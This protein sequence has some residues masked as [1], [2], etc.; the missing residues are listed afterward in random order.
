VVVARNSAKRFRCVPV[1]GDNND[2]NNDDCNSNNTCGDSSSSHRAPTETGGG[3]T[4]C[5]DGRRSSPEQVVVR[6]SPRAPAVAFRPPSPYNRY[7]VVYIYAFRARVIRIPLIVTI[8]YWRGR[9]P[10]R[11]RPSRTHKLR[12]LFKHPTRARRRGGR[13][14]RW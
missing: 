10:A 14:G 12:A 8:S 13:D 4:T 7:T 6:V 11:G 2:Y 5:S 3:G 1:T 9:V